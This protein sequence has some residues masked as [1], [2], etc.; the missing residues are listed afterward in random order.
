[1][2]EQADRLCAGL[3]GRR[4]GLCGAST[5]DI[6]EHVGALGRPRCLDSNQLGSEGGRDPARDLVLQGKQ[7][8][9]DA[10]ES[11]RP[12]MRIGFGVDQLRIDVGLVA[13]ALDAPLE[14][15]ADTEFAADP[16][17]VDWLPLN[18]KAVLLEITNM[19]AIRDRSVVTSSVSASAKY[20]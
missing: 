9:G 5:Q 20:C 11:L 3:G 18:V 10:V 4:T 13:R 16:L 1:M 6:V 14:D 8:G 7:I 15:V 19:C 2:L 17:C 12:Q